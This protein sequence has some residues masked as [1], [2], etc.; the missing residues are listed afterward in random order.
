[1]RLFT[2]AAFISLFIFFSF[3]SSRKENAVLSADSLRY[4]EEKHFKNLRQL[5]FG[6]DNAEAY[7]SFDSKM[8]SFNLTIKNGAWGATRS[9]TCPLR[10]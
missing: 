7:W 5:T 10:E 3:S 8:I 4:P 2:I 9:F 1:M 6:G